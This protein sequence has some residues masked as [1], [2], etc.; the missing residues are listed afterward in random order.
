VVERARLV[1]GGPEFKPWHYIK[2]EKETRT[3]FIAQWEMEPAEYSENW[4][5]SQEPCLGL[6]RY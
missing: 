1:I 2:K 6:S 4:W 5:A 3:F